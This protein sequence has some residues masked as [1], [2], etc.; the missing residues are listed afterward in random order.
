MIVYVCNTVVAD[1][2]IG[3]QGKLDCRTRLR[4][5]RNKSARTDV[6]IGHYDGG[7]REQ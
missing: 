2:Y 3:P 4:W 6:G 7:I 1:A 5:T